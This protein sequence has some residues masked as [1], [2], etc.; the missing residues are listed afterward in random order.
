[1]FI[2]K[3]GCK[4]LEFIDIESWDLIESGFTRSTMINLDG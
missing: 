2:R 4:L 3:L 1:M